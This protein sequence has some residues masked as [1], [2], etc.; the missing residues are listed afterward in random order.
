M[1]VAQRNADD[2]LQKKE[3]ENFS[4]EAF[5]SFF[6]KIYFFF[7]ELDDFWLEHIFDITVS[8]LSIYAPTETNCQIY[9]SMNTFLYSSLIHPQVYKLPFDKIALWYWPAS[10]RLMSFPSKLW[11]NN[12]CNDWSTPLPMPSCPCW[13]EPIAYSY[14]KKLKNVK[15]IALLQNSK[16]SFDLLMIPIFLHNFIDLTYPIIG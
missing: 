6:Q 7:K 15:R 5:C 4:D 2:I 10:I 16:C 14:K 9:R 11:T 3:V 13:L 8:E 12:G 1:C